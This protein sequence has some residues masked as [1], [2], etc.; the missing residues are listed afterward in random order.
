MRLLLVLPLWH[1]VIYRFGTLIR[2]RV[3]TTQT[4]SHPIRPCTLG[5][6]P[7]HKYLYSLVVVVVNSTGGALEAP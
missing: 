3:G 7:V 2:G 4:I 6:T 5:A 1:P